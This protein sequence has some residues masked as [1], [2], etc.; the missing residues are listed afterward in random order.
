[1]RYRRTTEAAWLSHRLTAEPACSIEIARYPG[2]HSGA[3]SVSLMLSSLAVTVFSYFCLCAAWPSLRVGR[4]RSVFWAAA[5]S[6]FGFWIAARLLGG[7]LALP[8]GWV[9]STWLSATVLGVPLAASALA[10]R[11]FGKTAR[12]GSMHVPVLN[13]SRR[14]FL[15]SGLALPGVAVSMGVGGASGGAHDFVVR[16]LELPIGG[17]PRAFD[18]FRI[19]QISDVHVGDFIRPELLERAVDE[20]NRA[21]VDLQVMTGDL[22]DDLSLLDRTLLALGQSTARHGM[23]TVLGNHEKFRGLDRVLAAYERHRATSNVRLLVDESVVLDHGGARLRVV[24]VDY[25]MRSTGSRTPAK[26]ERRALMSASAERAFAR[27]ARDETVLCLSHHPEFFPIAAEKGALLTLAGHTHGG[28][29]AFLGRPLL[30]MYDYMLGRYRRGDAQLYV[31]PGT[32][33]WMPFRVG[34]PT[35][36]TILTLRSAPRRAVY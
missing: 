5:T 28:Q 23:L 8:A 36:V 3:P 22:I 14:R 21:R 10:W 1:M 25:P 32:G 7:R 6:V 20:M 16:H 4:P 19:G 2:R 26:V 12:G 24:G 27:V 34:V 11:W 17:L 33:H 35:E 13:E 29:V 9:V 30:Q 15:G 31:S 18:G